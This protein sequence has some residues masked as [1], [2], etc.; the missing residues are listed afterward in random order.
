MV[1]AFDTRPAVREQVE[2]LGATFLEFEFDEAGEGEGGYAKEMSEAY[3]AAEQALIAQHAKQSDIIITTALIPGKPAPQLITSGAVVSMAHGSVIVDMAAEQGGNCALTERDKV[4][5]E[6]RR[7]DHRLHRS[8]E[9]HG[10]PVERALRDDGLQPARGSGATGGKG[11]LVQ[12]D[13]E[14][15]IHRG[16]LVLKDGELMWPPP[17]RAARRARRRRRRRGAKARRPRAGAAAPT[18]A[19]RWARASGWRCASRCSARPG[20]SARPSSCST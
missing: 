6:V 4:V 2:S 3:L 15:E 1:R 14:D 7:H 5:A 13:L 16:V 18:A 11:E 12:I 19:E 8:A 10:A 20:C 9:P 17:K